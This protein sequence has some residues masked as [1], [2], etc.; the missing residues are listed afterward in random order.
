VET[1]LFKGVPCGDTDPGHDLTPRHQSREQR[2]AGGFFFLSYRQ[3]GEE[4]SRPWMDA[5]AGLAH[6]VQLK[7]MSHGSVG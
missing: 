6:I 7:G 2:F 3:G 4:S 5:G 1:S